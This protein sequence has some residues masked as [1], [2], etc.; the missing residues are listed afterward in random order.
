MT[1]RWTYPAFAGYGIE[2]EYAIVDALTLDVRPVANDLLRTLVHR[3]REKSATPGLEDR[4]R[5]IVP[6]K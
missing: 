6:G 4:T 1:A 3:G 2:L 5:R